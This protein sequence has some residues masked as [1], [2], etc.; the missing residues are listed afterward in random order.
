MRQKTPSYKRG[1]EGGNRG[2]QS[3]LRRAPA[4]P[5]SGPGA[6]GKGALAATVAMANAILTGHSANA[7]NQAAPATSGTGSQNTTLP[8]VD[9]FGLDGYRADSLSLQKYSQPL[10]TTPQSASVVTPQLMQDQGVTDMR[11][12]LRNVSGVSIG[13][14]EGSYQ[15]DNFSIRGFNARS[16]I[17]LDGM[18][19]FGDYDRDPFDMEQ[20]DVLKGPSSA[21]FGRGSTGGAVNTVSKMPQLY[22]FTDIS[23]EAGSDQTKRATLDFNE[24]ISGLQGSAFRLNLMGDGSKVTDRDDASYARWGIAPSVVFGLGTST[25][26]WLNYFHQSEDNTPDYGVPWLF[27][28][29]APVSWGSFYGF[30]G[31]YF[32]TNVNIGTLRLE[33]D[34]N[35]TFTLREQFRGG[36]YGRDFRISQADTSAIVPGTP[37]QEMQVG[38][39]IIDADSNDRLVDEDINL[40]S[41]FDTGP[42]SHELVTGL[43]Y[44]HQSVD[45]NRIEPGWE[46]VPN[47]SLLY[48]VTLPFPGYGLT[49][50]S[51]NAVVDT[52]S[53]Y[54]IDTVKIAKKW[55]FIGAVRYDHI[56]SKY[57]EIEPPATTLGSKNDLPS[58]RTALVYQPRPNGSI[59]LAAG[60][61]IHPNIA[62][63]ALSSETTLPASVTQI[64]VGKNLEFE[65]GTK[66]ELF[67]HHVLLSSA[68]FW[69]QLTNPAAVDLDDPLTNVFNG[70]ERVIGLELGAVGKL[71]D[72]WQVL[73]NYTA[74]EG[75]VTAASD[76]SY[77]GNPIVNAP[78]NTFSLWTT[79][80][81]PWS[82]QAGF[83]ANAVSSRTATESPDPATGLLL[84]APGYVIYSA[85]LKYRVN[86]NL[87]L[88]FNVTNLTDKFYYD[89]VHPGHVVPGEGRTF[90][91]SANLRF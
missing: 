65:T 57:N 67:E 43:E 84:Q 20:I 87:D 23:L 2:K 38:R 6:L 64:A 53:L 46:N 18:T 80:D 74:Q 71:T 44:V 30:Q 72:K 66:W 36:S 79:Y 17:F 15:G 8:E 22:N 34:F 51:V 14:G 62:Q 32:K 75:K 85:M 35:D 39:D 40:L 47:T 10:L 19:D 59:Y 48:P 21:E 12:A 31:D 55:T 37:L 88:Q 81:L 50:T 26:L 82:F 86:K 58:W 77:I 54:G 42:L 41:K 24:P 33:H 56:V 70:K 91:L 78:K 73:A 83:G 11:D 45:P 9:V 60:T 68:L 52:F 7:D 69:D 1:E 29:P 27:D 90:F 4:M 61:S 5:R 89:G 28:R 3:T 63:L 13:A 16:D 25:R 49:S 76:P